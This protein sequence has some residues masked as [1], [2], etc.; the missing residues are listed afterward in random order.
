MAKAINFKI[1][2]LEELIKQLPPLTNN[3]MNRLEDAANRGG[4]IIL[5]KAISKAPIGYKKVNGSLEM[6]GKLMENLKWKPAKSNQQQKFKTSGY[7]WF[8]DDTKYGIYV[9]LGHK[10]VRNGKTIKTVQEKPFLRPAADESRTKVRN[11]MTDALND[12]IKN[13]G[14]E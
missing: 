7:V 8:S 4:N 6:S 12:V 1:D 2:G 10:L 5:Q 9:E 11:I 14:G 3:A 13:Y